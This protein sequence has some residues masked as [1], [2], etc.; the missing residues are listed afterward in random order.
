MDAT[1][2]DPAQQFVGWVCGNQAWVSYVLGLLAAHTGLSVL[3]AS[4]KKM[5]ITADSPIIGALIPVIRAL[6][7]DVK[8]PP[9]VIVA[10]AAAI[11]ASTPELA[12]PKV[13]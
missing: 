11:Q 2:I 9:A 3:S 8:P 13:T 6:A 4:L 12:Q 5:G 1:S 7:M 10:Q